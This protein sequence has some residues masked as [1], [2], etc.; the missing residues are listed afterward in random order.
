MDT[1]DKKYNEKIRFAYIN[2]SGD[3]TSSAIGL[4]CAKKQNMFWEMYN[5]LS[6]IKTKP[7][8]KEIFSFANKIG[9]DKEKFVKDFQD[10]T[11]SYSIINNIN[12]LHDKGFWGVPSIVVNKH[13]V[14]DV[15]SQNAIEKAI[16]NE[17]AKN[18]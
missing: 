7:S 8:C 18:N 3:I 2:Y 17:L 11:T 15:Y 9:L 13:I 1:N 12:Q 14:L 10:S 4:E 16:E 5:Q 6:R